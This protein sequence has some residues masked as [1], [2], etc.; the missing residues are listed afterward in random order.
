M[1]RNIILTLNW[2]QIAILAVSYV[3]ILDRSFDFPMTVEGFSPATIPHVEIRK[4]LTTWP[5]QWL[6][7]PPSDLRHSFV[8]IYI[9]LRKCR[10]G[11]SAAVASLWFPLTLTWI[12]PSLG[13]GNDAKYKARLSR[14][15]TFG[16]RCRRSWQ[17]GLIQ[18]TFINDHQSWRCQ[19]IIIFFI[20]T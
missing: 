13:G 19:I 7:E 14:R 15:P 12:Q 17:R 18:L 5:R 10:R 8:T 20:T 1:C 4:H 3:Y 16:H 9:I 6:I 2:T 11:E